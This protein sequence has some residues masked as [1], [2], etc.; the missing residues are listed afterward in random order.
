MIKG[1]KHSKKTRINGIVDDNRIENLILFKN[2]SEHQ[3]FHK[4]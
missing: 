3:K 1:S 4:L 2:Q